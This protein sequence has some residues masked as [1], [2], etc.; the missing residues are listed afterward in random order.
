MRRL[1]H[2]GLLLAATVL[3][4]AVPA[5][6][7]LEAGNIAGR[8]T[9]S[10]GAVI[11][12][13]KVTLVNK[14]TSLTIVQSTNAEGIFN[15]PALQPGTYTVTAKYK[16]FEQSE[17]TLD[18]TVGGTAHADMS[19]RVGSDS[20]TVEVVSGGA[21]QLETQN[22]A[23][24][25]VITT[26]EVMDLPMDG[27]NPYSL[28]ALVP[29]IN[30]GQYFGVGL[31]EARGALQ[32]AGNANY[33]ASGGLPGSNEVLLDGVPITVC[34]QGQPALT[35]S[36][37]IVQQLRVTNSIP[38]AQYG[39]TSGG[40]LNYS[41]FSGENT[42]HGLIYE[43]FQ[44]TR[45]HAAP[46]FTKVDQYLV[47]PSRPGDYRLPLHYNQY[48]VG[49]GGPVKIPHLYNG[50]DKT[51]FFA[52]YQGVD[53]SIAA[54]NKLTV[55]SNN[56]RHGYFNEGCQSSTGVQ[57]LNCGSGD[58]TSSLI[59]NPLN[60]TN[61]YYAAYGWILKRTPFPGNK[62]NSISPIAAA[63]L[64][65]IPLPNNPA[66]LASTGAIDC[67]TDPTDTNY[68]AI[69]CAASVNGTA[70]QTVNNFDKLQTTRRRDQQFSIR[71]DHEFSSRQRL[72]A[73]TT[74]TYNHDHVPD[75]FA[76]YTGPNSSH[77]NIAAI[78]GA[79]QDTWMLTNNSVL[80][81]Q[82]GL[83]YQRNTYIPGVFNYS[84]ADAGFNSYYA[85]LQ[86]ASGMPSQSIDDEN[87]V[88]NSSSTLLQDMYT[89]SF[90]ASVMTQRGPHTLV[91]GIDFRDLLWM[92]K[93]Q[94]NPLGTFS[95][96]AGFVSGPTPNTPINGNIHYM[97]VADFMLGYASTGSME[98][99]RPTAMTQQYGALFVQDN[100][101]TSAKLTLNLGVRY[102]VETGPTERHNHY[103]TFDPTIQNPVSAQVGF[104]FN[105]GLSFR[106]VNG[107]SR[108]YF[109]TCW[110]EF[111]PRIGFA[112]AFDKDTVL[113]GGFGILNLPTSQRLYSTSNNAATATTDYVDGVTT[114]PN[115]SAGSVPVGMGNP[116]PNGLNPI[117]TSSQGA[118]A[119]IG[120]SVGGLLYNTPYSYVEQWSI[121]LQQSLATNLM[122]S[123]G[124]VG[125]HGVKLPISFNPN[126]MR[127]SEFGAT[128][129]QLN[130]YVTNPF[131]GL[132]KG[133]TYSLANIQDSYLVT[134][135]P[136]FYSAGENYVAQGSMSYNSLQASLRKR[137]SNSST[138]SVS[139]T[140]SKSLG[141]V[142]NLVT[143]GIDTGT[144]GRQ[145]SYFPKQERSY[146]T[147]DSPQIV[148]VAFTGKIPYGR[149]QRFGR[150]ARGW[151]E[152]VFSNWQVNGV[153]T[154]ASG[155]PL[156]IGET[157]QGQFGGNRPNIVPGQSFQTGG[158]IRQRL[159]GAYSSNGYLN[160]AAFS[161]TPALQFG[162]MPRLCALCRVPRSN[163][164]NASL[165]KIIPLNSRMT[166]QI[167]AEMF[168]VWNYVQFSAPNSTF[169]SST[170]GEI[171]S[172]AN[173]P[174]N[175]QLAM[176]LQW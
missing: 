161:L 61:T 166:M 64:K 163:N 173:Y 91:A 79:L 23:S 73:R 89:H 152:I 46:Y 75:E 122:F 169:N 105:G 31:T 124:Y 153:V 41:T 111:S 93:S 5:Q 149:G 126:N 54:F 167:R 77:Q 67:S 95:Y 71:L 174:R 72:L 176:R 15:F 32:M 156:H 9:D 42:V 133:G 115:V 119:G 148:S 63:T 62:I 134:K 99:S 165:F 138:L 102:D 127:P 114:I 108:H 136:Q 92:N 12:N 27:G 45:L 30:T 66:P 118:A 135:Y 34:C 168:N 44:N 159:G 172:Q 175:L 164:V 11:R 20:A 160:P 58:L 171:T 129:S 110:N 155:R 4:S 141:D 131:Y 36:V 17:T 18:L 120:T 147:N 151:R 125:S 139:Y 90:G 87:T 29:G 13:A 76:S 14:G 7:Q 47:N 137:W 1:I 80:T 144:P 48:G 101:R 154:F 3:L 78:V 130:S 158:S 146:S 143:G 150:T 113:R 59:Y 22:A 55:P 112:Y 53:A 142:D 106:G 35:P 2:L 85:S 157:G 25:F 123:L 56:M 170:F 100:W 82:Y 33:S 98:L 132:V 109:N 116:F 40:T 60:Y 39:R 74:Y 49:L 121:S 19:L 37:A 69:A 68:N 57:D 65:L 50:R 43:S 21:Y 145:D 28:A 140:W 70:D 97:S 117:P 104:P 86:Q 24:D 162:N 84:A 52:G 83:A 10:T 96:T 103:A 128:V 88:G 81:L 8:I 26:K 16:G 38:S 6:G 107:H 94:N 51:F